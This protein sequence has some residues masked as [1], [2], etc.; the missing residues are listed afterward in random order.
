MINRDESL[1]AADM[2]VHLMRPTIQAIGELDDSDMRRVDTTEILIRYYQLI[3][4]A[5]WDSWCD[6]FTE[7][8]VMDEQLAGRIEGKTKLQDMVA[9]FGDLYQIFQHVPRH[10]IV[11]GMEAAAISHITAVTRAG[12]HIEAEVMNY[13]RIGDGLITYMA[14][15]H[16]TVPFQVLNGECGAAAGFTSKGESYV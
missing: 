15:V 14:N 8:M 11:N 1:T 4:A 12:N 16:D 5:D 9:G 13:F 10:F 2:E 7:D 3:N 6:L